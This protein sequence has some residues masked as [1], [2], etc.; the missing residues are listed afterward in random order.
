MSDRLSSSSLVAPSL[1]PPFL[2]TAVIRP[3]TFPIATR[4]RRAF[5]CAALRWLPSWLT[6]MSECLSFP[7]FLPSFLPSFF[8][9]ATNAVS[10]ERLC[11]LGLS[12][13]P[14]RPRPSLLVLCL[15]LTG[16]LSPS[17]RD[18]LN[19]SSPLSLSLFLS[20]PHFSISLSPSLLIAEWRPASSQAAHVIPRDLPRSTTAWLSRVRLPP[21]THVLPSSRPSVRP[22][23]RPSLG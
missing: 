19:A 6:V 3:I 11:Y 12:P 17:C 4:R 16:C 21:S 5:V 2:P 18:G 13:H 15:R 9:E 20:I 1:L 7:S 10:S 23:V 14:P 22:S 8:L